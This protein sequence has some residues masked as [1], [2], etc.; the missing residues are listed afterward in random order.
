MCTRGQENL[1]KRTSTV[2][3]GLTVA[4][5]AAVGVGTS[6]ATGGSGDLAQAQHVKRVSLHESTEHRFDARHRVGTDELR[7]AGRTVGYDSFAEYFDP[8][9]DVFRFALSFKRGQIVGRVIRHTGSAIINGP[10][11][12][13]TGRFAGIEGR[14]T[15]NIDPVKP[16]HQVLVLRYRL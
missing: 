5:L 14:A 4:A 11:L 2:V 8:T 9:K 12:F 3:L 15:L 10:I 6:A 7:H 1:M 16:S 13:G